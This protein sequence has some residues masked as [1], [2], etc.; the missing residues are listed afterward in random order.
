MFSGLFFLVFLGGNGLTMPESAAVFAC[1][2]VVIHEQSLRR[3]VCAVLGRSFE[4]YRKKFLNVV[5]EPG[6]EESL[7]RTVWEIL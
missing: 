1:T 5:S 4:N 2:Q 6:S 7:R 3:T